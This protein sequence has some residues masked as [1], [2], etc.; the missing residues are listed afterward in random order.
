MAE[1]L[2]M[3]N[4]ADPAPPLGSHLIITHKVGQDVVV[5]TAVLPQGHD[6]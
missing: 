2:C 6:L 3:Q 1:S 4:R 5:T